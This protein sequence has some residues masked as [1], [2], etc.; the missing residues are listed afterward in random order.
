MNRPTFPLLLALALHPLAAAPSAAQWIQADR[1]GAVV[2]LDEAVGFVPIPRGTLFCPLLADPKE[3]RSFASYQRGTQAPF[4]TDIGAVG[5]GDQFGIARWGGPTAGEGVQ[6]AVVGAVFAQFDLATASYDLINADYLI[7]LAATARRAGF[8][9]RLRLYHQSS[10]L[11]DEFLL[12]PATDRENLSFEAVHLLLSQEMGALRVYLGGETLLRREPDD[13]ARTVAQAGLEL[14]QPG[15]PLRVGTLGSARLVA[16]VDLKATEEQD[17][18]PATSVRAG[19]D[20]GRA[21]P[22]DGPSRRWQV[23]GEFYDGPTPYGQFFRDAIRYWGVGM[24][25]SL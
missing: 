19:I 3:A 13:L 23:L 15:R 9:T 6:L 18:S 16:G 5:I 4:D 10:H 8:T 17:W 2:P 25:F 11:G 14:R 7:G 21:R 1:C 12:R 22:A 24:H 20:V